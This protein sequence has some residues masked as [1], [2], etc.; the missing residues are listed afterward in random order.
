MARSIS[1][2][3]AEAIYTRNNYLQLTELNSGRTGSKLSI[4]NL[5]TYVMSVLIHT[6]ETALDLF[7]LNVADIIRNR[8]NGTPAYYA[9]VAKHFQFNK[10]TQTGDRLY[11]ND[12]TYKIGYETVD[13]SHRII[14]QANWEDYSQKDAIILKVCK[15]NTNNDEI[16]GGTVYTQLSDAELTAFKQYIAAIKFCGAR[17]Y[18]LSLPG[19]VISFETSS[20]A[21]VYYD[22]SIVTREQ[23]IQNIKA[24][25]AAYARE[26]EFGGFIH[27]QK[28][29]DVLQNA[30]GITD[31][32]ANAK[33]KVSMY[34]RQKN[35]Y[36]DPINITGRIRSVSGYL[37]FFTSSGVSTI[38]SITLR[39]ESQRD[40]VI[41]VSAVSVT[42]KKDEAWEQVNGAWE[43]SVISQQAT[44]KTYTQEIIKSAIQLERV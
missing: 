18:C 3:Y 5:L 35:T 44:D 40:S 21:P 38:D 17:I 10:D 33:V 30:E 15:D 39:A 37:R 19:D 26:F 2:I 1:Q 11:F 24:A 6:Y 28:I 31:I 32:S 16:D 34:N 42:R 8:I 12:E 43:K 20:N 23:A 13:E 29:I 7:Q 36:D 14:A 22:D 27:Y 9:A 41:D 4:L 25:M